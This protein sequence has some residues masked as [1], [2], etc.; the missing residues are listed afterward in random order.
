MNL[1]QNT[2]RNNNFFIENKLEDMHVNSDIINN[3]KC[4]CVNNNVKILLTL[5]TK[6]INN[7]ELYFK[8]TGKE[9][10]YILNKSICVNPGSIV[11]FKLLENNWELMINPTNNIYKLDSVRVNGT[12]GILANIFRSICINSFN[13]NILHKNEK[14]RSTAIN[15]LKR[16]INDNVSKIIASDKIAK[17]SKSVGNYMSVVLGTNVTIKK[18][19]EL[20]CVLKIKRVDIIVTIHDSRGRISSHGEGVELTNLEIDDGPEHD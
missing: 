20:L 3:N 4:I 5:E 13:L 14:V 6:D 9:A 11:Y 15:T 8:N 19:L 16:I 1:N 7:D 12:G 18:F 17:R 10:V 2:Y